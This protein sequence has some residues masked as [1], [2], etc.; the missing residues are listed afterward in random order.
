MENIERTQM[1]KRERNVS[2]KENSIHID[3]CST[4][5]ISN[6]FGFRKKKKRIYDM[7]LIQM[8]LH[9]SLSSLH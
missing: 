3:T 9:H 7:I 2:E 8:E 1:N 4:H 6:N 5:I